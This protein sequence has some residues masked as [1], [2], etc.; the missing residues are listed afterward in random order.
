MCYGGKRPDAA[1]RENKWREVRAE[2][3]H[4]QLCSRETNTQKDFKAE[5]DNKEETE[6]K[7]VTTEHAIEKLCDSVESRREIVEVPARLVGCAC[8]TRMSGL[9]EP[10]LDTVLVVTRGVRKAAH[11]YGQF[12][13]D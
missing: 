6:K 5:T 4:A 7:T 8:E 11:R 10:R 3:V 1:Q 13:H 9:H 2:V 12:W